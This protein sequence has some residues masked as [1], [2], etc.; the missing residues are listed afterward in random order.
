MELVLYC[1]TFVF[2]FLAVMSNMAKLVCCWH[3]TSRVRVVSLT[4]SL[5]WG[6]G[7]DVDVVVP[8]RYFFIQPA[9]TGG[10]KYV[11]MIHSLFAPGPIRSP[12]RIGQ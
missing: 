12:E 8:V 2:L 10:R 6:P 3:Q 7:L 5:V 1:T 4:E 9:D 11:L